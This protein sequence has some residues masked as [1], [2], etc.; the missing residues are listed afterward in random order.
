MHIIGT[1]LAV[2]VRLAIP[3]VTV[4]GAYNMGGWLAVAATAGW[5]SLVLLLFVWGAGRR[6]R[7]VRRV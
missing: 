7:E 6:A 3:A 2:V 5:G 4:W 1:A